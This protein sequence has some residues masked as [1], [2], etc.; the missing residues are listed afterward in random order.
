MAES[1]VDFQKKAYNYSEGKDLFVKKQKRFQDTI[2]VPI[3]E[4]HLL[5]HLRGTCHKQTPS[6]TPDSP[7]ETTGQGLGSVLLASL[8]VCFIV[9]GSCQLGQD[10]PSTPDS[11]AVSSQFAESLRKEHLRLTTGWI[12]LHHSSPLHPS[13][14]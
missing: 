11:S 4:F 7:E 8:A 10:L 13:E 2:P 6:S 3:S 12:P 1:D 5:N 14:R 9:F